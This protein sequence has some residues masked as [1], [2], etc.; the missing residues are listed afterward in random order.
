MVDDVVLKKVATVERCV[1]RARAEYVKDPRTVGDDFTRQ[2][3]A[4]LNIQRACEASLDLGQA[5]GPS[6]T[7][8]LSPKRAGCLYAPGAGGLD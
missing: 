2:D 6:P 7:A 1:G 3:A 5:Y 8:R 4:V